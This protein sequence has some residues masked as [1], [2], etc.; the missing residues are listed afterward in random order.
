MSRQTKIASDCPPT[1]D[2]SRSASPPASRLGM[3][4]LQNLVRSIRHV[5]VAISITPSECNAGSGRR[6]PLL[7]DTDSDLT[8]AGHPH[9]L[10]PLLDTQMTLHTRDHT[11]RHT[12]GAALRSSRASESLSTPA[13]RCSGVGAVHSVY[14]RYTARYIYHTCRSTGTDDVVPTQMFLRSRNSSTCPGLEDQNRG[15]ERE[16]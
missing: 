7:V 9:W 6:E 13:A 4:A 11:T 14:V 3:P 2:R 15:F 16:P 10:V 8:T 5:L 12:D 1:A